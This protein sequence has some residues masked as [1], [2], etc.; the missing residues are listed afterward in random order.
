MTNSA[1]IANSHLKPESGRQSGPL[2]SA[3][4]PAQLALVL[5]V[6]IN[7]LNLIDRQILSAVV[8]MLRVEFFAGGQPPNPAV[9]YFLDR[10]SGILGGNAEN[11]MLGLLAMAFM[12]PYTVGAPLFASFKTRRWTMV[13]GAVIIFSLA[14]AMT[15]WAGGF[16]LLLI[17][18]C[19]VGLGESA[20][21][22]VAPSII[23]DHFPVNV[24]GRVM[25]YFYL[26]LPL[27]SALG[28]VLGGQIAQAHGWRAVFLVAAVP[29][30]VLGLL[31]YFMKEPNTCASGQTASGAGKLIMLK[32]LL[33]NRSFV[34]VT[35]GE[36][37][38]TFA[39]GGMVFWM[40]SYIYE[41]RGAG[42]LAQVNLI[43]GAIVVLAGTAAT[44]LG[45]QAAERLKKRRSGAY[46]LVSGW[47]MLLGFPIFVAALFIPFPFAWI[48][49]FL[50]TFCLLFNTGPANTI[51][52]DVNSAAV[53]TFAYSVNIFTIHALG[54]V[55]SPLIIGAVADAKGMNI[56][57]LFVSLFFLIG[58]TLW[59]YGARFLAD[60]TQRAV[61]QDSLCD[62]NAGGNSDNL[63]A[64]QN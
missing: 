49:M 36:A 47:A 27:G 38:M 11:A 53:R 23:A 51:I 55:I 8:P 43:F 16:G 61:R 3:S 19:L 39:I 29:G 21:A 64:V 41:F 32:Q 52:A 25:P 18:R 63:A 45:A 48:L 12:L 26:A 28:F 5:L 60:D 62:V 59:L 50:A 24:R 42:S 20:F 46:F 35:L 2:A 4:R 33:E 57:F 7:L 44:F 58:G 40:P 17:A 31:S 54:D 14:T 15:G 10:L 34:L 56:A 37:A 1:T 22:P 9:R 13:G 6:A 30:L